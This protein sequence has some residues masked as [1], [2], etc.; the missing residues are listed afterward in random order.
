MVPHARN[1]WYSKELDVHGEPLRGIYAGRNVSYSCDANYGLVGQSMLLCQE[2][3]HFDIE[4]PVCKAECAWPSEVYHGR[5]TGDARDNGNGKVLLEGQKVV[6][7]CEEGRYLFGRHY[8]AKCLSSHELDSPT[9]VCL[10]KV[11]VAISGAEFFEKDGVKLEGD[12]VK[13]K[14]FPKAESPFDKFE[15]YLFKAKFDTSS[16]AGAVRFAMTPKE[17]VGSFL[18]VEL[19]SKSTMTWMTSGSTCKSL[20]V[21]KLPPPSSQRSKESCRSCLETSLH[22]AA[23]ALRGGKSSHDLTLVLPLASEAAPEKPGTQ[24][25]PASPNVKV[26]LSLR[27]Q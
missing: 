2:N 21:S 8:W 19:C 3:G 1:S 11:E 22:L 4:P 7:T 13:V 18:H 17:A 9:P 27:L 6:F 24:I 25:D 26:Q 14:I 5:V 15:G 16:K 20:G 23:E 12:Y 10:K